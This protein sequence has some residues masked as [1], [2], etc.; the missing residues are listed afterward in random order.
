MSVTVTI[1]WTMLHITDNRKKI[2]VEESTIGACFEEVIRRHPRLKKELYT[3]SGVLRP[4]ILIYVND[5][6][7]HA[8][9]LSRA[10]GAGD[11]IHITT[12]VVGG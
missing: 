10:V 2:E 12:L 5:T 6:A 8:N 4:E 1:P 9:P 7:V 3:E 11:I